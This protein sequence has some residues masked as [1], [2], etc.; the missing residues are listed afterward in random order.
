MSGGHGIRI[1]R[2]RLVVK[3]NLNRLGK[4]YEISQDRQEDHHE[5]DHRRHVFL[6]GPPV[7]NR[8][9]P[10]PTVRATM[11]CNRE[12]V[13]ADRAGFQRQPS[14]PQIPLDG[15][16]SNDSPA[17]TAEAR[18]F[19]SDNHLTLSPDPCPAAPNY[20]PAPDSGFDPAAIRRTPPESKTPFQNSLMG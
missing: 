18:R 19:Q 17:W 15:R 12:R 16:I 5:H 4:K 2:R 3:H 8:R 14:P 1:S 11:F 13:A 20:P 10:V 7:G 6:Q 9:L